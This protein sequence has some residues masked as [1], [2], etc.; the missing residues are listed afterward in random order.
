[1]SSAFTSSGLM[2]PWY[3]VKLRSRTWAKLSTSQLASSTNVLPG[4]L[5]GIPPPGLASDAGGCGSGSAHESCAIVRLTYGVI[6]D[7]IETHDP[8]VLLQENRAP[9]QSGQRQRIREGGYLL[10]SGSPNR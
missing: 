1:M 8:D 9:V 10:D 6:S 4:C 3:R 7:T 2:R 5:R